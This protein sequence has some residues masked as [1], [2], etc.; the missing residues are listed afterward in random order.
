M[1]TRL[2]DAAYSD[3]IMKAVNMTDQNPEALAPSPLLRIPLELRRDIYRFS[4]FVSRDPSAEAIYLRRCPNDSK[5]P[6]S[7]LLV[8]NSQI[9][10]EVV[11]MV[12]IYPIFLRVTRQ[13]IRF[14]SLAETCFI[15]QRHS[16]DYGKI[17][18]LFIEIQPPHPDRPTNVID[19]WRQLRN[20]RKELCGV[21]P[22][23]RVSFFFADNEMA[24]WTQ[25]GKALNLLSYNGDPSVAEA[26]Y[27]D[28]TKIME[29]FARVSA[30]K[31]SWSMP[32][33]LT[34]GKTT[35][36]VRDWLHAT[37][38]WMMGRVPIDED[39]YSEEDEEQ[40]EMQD[41]WDELRELHLQRD[42]VRIARDKLDRMTGGGSRNH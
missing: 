23:Q 3:T 14:D 15:A 38:D 16:R 8:A 2:Q 42:G 13:G 30:A 18:H 25:N 19:I 36:R 39:F 5:D 17:P 7:P 28:V 41:D 20:C 12:Q 29:L 35:D 37:N 33:G 27:N 34:P 11:D 31:A 1:K 4:L 24:A 10:A 21:P 32:R 22:L 40:A 9:G 6:P 26:G